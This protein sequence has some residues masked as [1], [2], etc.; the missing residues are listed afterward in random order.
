MDEFENI[1]NILMRIG[2]SE[3][4]KDNYIMR[5]GFSGS[6][7]DNYINRDIIYYYKNYQVY[8]YTINHITYFKDDDSDMPLEFYNIADFKNHLNIEFKFIMRK[9]KVNKMF[10]CEKREIN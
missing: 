1:Q 10:D 4:T 3:S 9:I 6:T 7:K 5:I 2:F 8:I